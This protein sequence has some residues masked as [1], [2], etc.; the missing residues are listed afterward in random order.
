MPSSLSA[1]TP[2]WG[3]LLTQPWAPRSGRPAKVTIH[4]GP[5]I[6]PRDTPLALVPIQPI[7]IAVLSRSVLSDSLGP[8]GW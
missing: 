5:E 2:I 8:H 4:S 7:S 3:V 1:R 6:R